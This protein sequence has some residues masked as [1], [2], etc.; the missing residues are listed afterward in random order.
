MVISDLDNRPWFTGGLW[1]EEIAKH[2]DY[3]KDYPIYRFLEDAAQEFPDNI[4]TIFFD[5]KIKY[6]D[7]WEKVLRF[8]DSL[9]KLGI[10]RGD[11]I[12]IYLPN[13]PQF[14]IAFFAINR[15]GALI[16]PF[17]TQYVDHELIYQLKDSGAR[18]IICIDITYDR[19]KNYEI[20]MR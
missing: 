18:T 5:A 11:R 6:K 16:V 9:Q 7:L 19:V 2:L 17:N 20:R 15:L 3:P 14:V 1:P 13:C 8:A 4:A 12:G 10:S